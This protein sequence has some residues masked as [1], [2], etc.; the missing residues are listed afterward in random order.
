[1]AAHPLDND[2]VA[3]AKEL[4]AGSHRKRVLVIK[5]P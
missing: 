2:R 5:T 1:M 3:R 4:A